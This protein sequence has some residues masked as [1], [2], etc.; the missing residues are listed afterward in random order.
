M[1]ATHWN[2]LTEEQ[3][4]AELS[5]RFVDPFF[6]NWVK[7]ERPLWL[8][9][10][11][12]LH[13]QGGGYMGPEAR[14]FLALHRGPALPREVPGFETVIIKPRPDAPKNEWSYAPGI[15]GEAISR[16]WSFGSADDAD[17]VTTWLRNAWPDLVD[18]LGARS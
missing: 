18:K 4:H 15:H 3:V 13:E 2:T 9:N 16:C 5:K 8:A 1:N 11:L 6:N 12:R 14:A 17:R 10:H 7:A